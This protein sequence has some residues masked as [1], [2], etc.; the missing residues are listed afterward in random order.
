MERQTGRRAAVCRSVAW[1]QLIVE[2]KYSDEAIQKNARNKLRAM[3]LEKSF[4]ERWNEPE[5]NTALVAKGLAQFS[6][7]KLFVWMM[8]MTLTFFLI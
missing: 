5:P 1:G 3:L 2:D 7:A 6:T 8:R 4:M